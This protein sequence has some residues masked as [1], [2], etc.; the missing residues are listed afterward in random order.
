M[1]K[2]EYVS[3][4]GLIKFG[5]NLSP[6]LIPFRLILKAGFATERFISSKYRFGLKVVGL[7]CNFIQVANQRL[8][9]LFLT[10][11]FYFESLPDISDSVETLFLI[12][13]CKNSISPIHCDTIVTIISDFHFRL[14]IFRLFLLVL[15][16]QI[17]LPEVM[18]L[19][20]KYCYLKVF[21]ILLRQLKTHHLLILFKSICLLIMN[22]DMVL[23]LVQNHQDLTLLLNYFPKSK[24]FLQ[25]QDTH[26]V[27]NKR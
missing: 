15:I 4:P 1:S 3:L 5:A 20:L 25:N 27:S 14:I 17:L 21:N 12:E 8:T 6:W 26:N 10:I 2:F 9:N 24:L 23:I 13:N 16:S 19:S 18:F 7:P 11:L 22:L